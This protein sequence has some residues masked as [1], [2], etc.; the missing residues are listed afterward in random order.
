MGRKTTESI[1]QMIGER[2]FDGIRQPG[3]IFRTEEEHQARAP[4]VVGGHGV[5]EAEHF[6]AVADQSGGMFQAG[7]MLGQKGAHGIAVEIA[8]QPETGNKG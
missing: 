3:M 1:G 7:E 2:I 4:V 6:R 8:A 5:V